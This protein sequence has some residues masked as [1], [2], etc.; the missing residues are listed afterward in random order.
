MDDVEGL[1]SA[2]ILSRTKH[3]SAEPVLDWFRHF[4]RG[5]IER[6]LASQSNGNPRFFLNLIQFGL[7]LL[8]KKLPSQPRSTLQKVH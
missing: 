4:R 2:R 3:F 8:L 5:A 1:E 6:S 7:S